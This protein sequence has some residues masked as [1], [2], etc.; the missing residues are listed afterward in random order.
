[1]ARLARARLL[2]RTGNGLSEIPQCNEPLTDPRQSAMLSPCLGHWMQFDPDRRAFITLLGGMA[3]T[4]PAQAQQA[5]VHRIGALLL[6]NADAGSFR[7]EMREELRKSGYVEG[8]N[9]L[10]DFRS[11]EGRLD[12]L[13]KMAAELVALKV[14]VIVA[15]Y[16]PCALAAQQATRDIP[17]IIVSGDPVRSGL[18][19]SLAHPGGNITGVSLMELHGKIV[20]LFRDMLPSVHRVAALGNEADPYRK[21]FLENIRL[22]G[23]AI[24]IEIAPAT[25][26]HG[27]D[28]IDAT[29]AVMKQDGADAVV[30]QGSL[31][32]KNVAELALKHGLP[33]AAISRSFAEVGGLMSYGHDE[34]DSFRRAAFFVI[35]VLQGG[36][37]ADI[38]I[39]QPTRFELV[40]NL[41]TAK[42]LGLTIPETFLLR[43]DKVIE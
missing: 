23:G 11:V 10:F 15:V 34:P 21:P 12:L 14:D 40:I 39:E 29:F 22:T 17:I 1:M 2:T 37:P 4:W 6:G 25:M 7:A 19:G 43:A 26:V 16:T 20:E 8:P 27:F 9:L 18:V 41:K 36:K 35:K 5:K 33:A 24:G 31:S 42:A 13:P 30:V 32:T 3:A 38:P 28:E